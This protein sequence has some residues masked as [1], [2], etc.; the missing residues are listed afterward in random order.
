MS[1][2]VEDRTDYEQDY[3][4]WALENAER[5][6]QG[7]FSDIDVEHIAEELE[8]MG[9]SEKHALSGHLKILVIAIT[10]H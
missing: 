10:E 7:R 3:Y 8:D 5:L 9:R 1:S 6:R 2:D 4:A